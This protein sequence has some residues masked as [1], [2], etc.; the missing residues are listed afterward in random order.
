MVESFLA[1]KTPNRQAKGVISFTESL[2]FFAPSCFSSLSIKRLTS[3]KRL[4][5]SIF[6]KKQYMQENYYRFN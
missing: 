1:T 2:C 3:Y 6:Q 4:I 5:Y